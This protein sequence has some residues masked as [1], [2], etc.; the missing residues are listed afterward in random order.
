MSSPTVLK[1][2]SFL[3]LYAWIFELILFIFFCFWKAII[4]GIDNKPLILSTVVNVTLLLTDKVKIYVV[5]ELYHSML[6]ISALTD[7]KKVTMH[8]Q[9]WRQSVRCRATCKVSSLNILQIGQIIDRLIYLC[10]KTT[11]SGS[12]ER[13]TSTFCPVS[14]PKS[15]TLEPFS[16]GLKETTAPWYKSRSLMIQ[17]NDFILFYHLKLRLFPQIFL[18]FPSAAP[19]GPSPS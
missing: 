12:Q 4:L 7:L 2:P 3:K 5:Q 1:F 8:S 9:G 10:W 14:D 17:K 11:F 15:S 13:E 19:F 16:W 6:H 18:L